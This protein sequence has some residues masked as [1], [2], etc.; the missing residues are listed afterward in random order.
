[1][2]LEDDFKSR[3]KEVSYY[4]RALRE[5][6][7]AHKTPGRG[8]YRASSA[9]AASRASAFLMI[10]NCVEFAVR[11]SIIAMRRDISANITDFSLLVPHWRKEIFRVHFKQKLEDGIN[12]E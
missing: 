9:I 11:E 6:E 7:N 8:F 12:H 1:M 5:L 4:L 2:S 3:L 10:Y